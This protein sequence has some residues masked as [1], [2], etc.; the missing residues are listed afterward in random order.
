MRGHR[1]WST[2]VTST[3]AVLTLA[4]GCGSSTPDRA[5]SP[6]A[7]T[8]TTRAAI[9]GTFTANGHEL[10]LECVGSGTPTMV[11][12]VGEARLHGDLVK[13]QDA[14]KPRLRVCSYDRA[15]KGAS[16]PAATPRK[17]A[18]IAA[19]LHDLLE[20]AKV[21]GPYLLVGHSAGGLIAQAY[22]ARY[23]DDVV[24]LVAINPVAPWKPW[25]PVMAKMSAKDRRSE[26]A[27]LTGNNGESLDYRDIGRPVEAGLAKQ[28]PSYVLV[29][30]P[31]ECPPDQESCPTMIRQ[32]D[33]VERQ[34]AHHWGA[35]FKIV[36]ASHDIHFDDLDAVTA[37]IDYVLVRTN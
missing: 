11:L 22:A 24:G 15:G 33:T 2:V 32:Y 9:S 12:E 14:Y 6:P 5:D 37:A 27:F 34:L 8:Q 35:G 17:G 3:I 16:G 18:D 20:V 21:P 23:P 36:D 10:Y 19:D 4:T 31:A 25:I 1:L 29:S 26:V 7:S 30:S 28:I 13:I